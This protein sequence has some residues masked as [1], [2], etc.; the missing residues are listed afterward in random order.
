[1]TDTQETQATAPPVEPTP[2]PLPI[3]E[4]TRVDEFAVSQFQG[5]GHATVLSE[6]TVAVYKEFKHRKDRL[7]PGRLTPEGMAFVDLMADIL[8]GN[9]VVDH[10]TTKES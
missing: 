6:T 7:Q 2:E 8:D 5:L 3:I 4:E 9:F 1:M 10:G